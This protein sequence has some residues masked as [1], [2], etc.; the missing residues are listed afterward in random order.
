MSETTRPVSG[1]AP[2]TSRGPDT[3]EAAAVGV[4]E[5]VGRAWGTAAAWE[6]EV[7]TL[8]ARLAGAEWKGPAL[9]RRAERL[10]RKAPPLV[11]G[12]SSALF[13]AAREQRQPWNPDE[14]PLRTVAR[15]LASFCDAAREL[16][17]L[18][19]EQELTARNFA[20]METRWAG[21]PRAW[22]RWTR[23]LELDRGEVYAGGT[24]RDLGQVR[25][26]LTRLEQEL[27][28]W[29]QELEGWLR[30]HDGAD[31]DPSLGISEERY[32]ALL[33]IGAAD[34]R[35]M[36]GRA[37]A[38]LRAGIRAQLDALGAPRTAE[39]PALVPELARGWAG[40]PPSEPLSAEEVAC[41][42]EV[43]GGAYAAGVERRPATSYSE[44]VDRAPLADVWYATPLDG[45]RLGGDMV[46]VRASPPTPLRVTPGGADLTRMCMEVVL[47][48][49]AHPLS[50]AE[51]KGF[52]PFF[53]E[54]ESHVPPYWWATRVPAWLRLRQV[55]GGRDADGRP[56]PNAIFVGVL[57]ER[58]R[59]VQ[60]P[61]P[62]KPRPRPDGD[63]PLFRAYQRPEGCDALHVH[64]DPR[65][66]DDQGK[67]L[68]PVFQS[69]QIDCWM[70]EIPEYGPMRVWLRTRSEKLRPPHA[71][72]VF[73]A[74]AEFFGR[75]AVALPGSVVRVA[76]RGTVDLGGRGDRAPCLATTAPLGNTVDR[77]LRA[78]D[79]QRAAE[80]GV[81]LTAD[82]LWI[83][84]AVHAQGLCVGVLSPPFLRARVACQ[85]CPPV[86]RA[87]LAAAPLAGSA[88]EPVRKPNRNRVPRWA[89]RAFVPPVRTPRADLV[90]LGRLLADVVAPRLRGDHA[91][92]RV[93]AELSGQGLPSAREAL[94]RLEAACPER[95]E[96]AR[97]AI[98]RAARTPAAA[99]P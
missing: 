30:R 7:R 98:V 36:L 60:L 62:P 84:E 85:V 42:R 49:S 91:L 55:G 56:A 58:G 15:E 52:R 39:L 79:P 38:L 40:L 51:V 83:L 50:P 5:R 78:A 20:E 54:V 90:S 16:L 37:A 6:T 92:R 14:D 63:P 33:S 4:R 99:Q 35:S 8:W 59:I 34:R 32:L 18:A 88:G 73:D 48:D 67:L 12:S 3:L 23:V 76:V 97:S 93:I 53:D 13:R 44:P 31:A 47:P 28:R 9:R 70:A 94:A 24:V 77:W 19:D 45:T 65:I 64:R 66:R 11:E 86:L 25:E 1:I 43:L 17:Q 80:W 2:P 72:S 57:E 71:P 68:P 69:P 46:V 22:R 89:T 87:T 26:R 29:H 81:D 41:Y 10:A 82:L 95:V 27:Q 61:D 74:E 75:L 96:H 21:F